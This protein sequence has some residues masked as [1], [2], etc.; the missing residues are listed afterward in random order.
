MLMDKILNI[1]I[2]IIELRHIVQHC[3]ECFFKHDETEPLI[4]IHSYPAKQKPNETL[5]Q[6][7]NNLNGLAAR[8]D[9]GNQTGGLVHD[10]F[11]LNMN[12]KQEREKLCT[13]PKETPAE[14]LQFAIAFED[15]LK[16][17]RS[18]GYINQEPRV[19]DDPVC[20]ISSS[21]NSKECWRCGA[22]NFTL[23]HMKKCKANNVMCNHCGRKGHL[24]RVC[25]QKKRE[26]NLNSGKP[27]TFGNSVQLVD[28]DGAGEDDEE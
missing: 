25:N 16:R 15:G 13:E 17:Q 10:I 14:A 5:N 8:C 6:F 23:D 2:L 4:A 26:A 1:N 12:N 18:Y 28:Q 27:R 22:V 19:K 20:A 11:I 3:T 24:E 21:N 7:W 9:F